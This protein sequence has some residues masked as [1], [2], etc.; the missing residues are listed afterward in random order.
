MNLLGETALQLYD[1]PYKFIQFGHERIIPMR[2]HLS[3]TQITQIQKQFETSNH[4]PEITFTSVLSR[5]QPNLL[6]QSATE[7]LFQP[8]DLIIQEGDEGD[9]L[10]IIRAGAVAVL[11]GSL[12]SP[13]VLG[14]RGPGEVVGEVALLDNRPRS[15]SLAAVRITRLL[16]IKREIIQQLLTQDPSASAS[17]MR[18]LTARLRESDNAIASIAAKGDNISSEVLHLRAEKERLLELQY[19][20]ED[21]SNLVVNDLRIPLGNITNAIGLL[22]MVLPPEIWNENLEAFE[23]AQRSAE[24]LTRMAESLLEMSRLESG[25]ITLHRTE[26]DLARLVDSAC[27]Q[28]TPLAQGPAIIMK[29]FA[30]SLPA[31]RADRELLLRVLLNL[32][33]NA[34]KHTPAGGIITLYIEPHRTRVQVA[35]ND[36]GTGVPPDQRERIFERFAHTEQALPS[37]SGFGLGLAFCRLAVEAHGGKIWAEDGENGV[38]TKFIFSLPIMGK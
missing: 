4:I 30:A 32:L 24:R 21:M 29:R 23:I 6:K 14:F 38:G 16:R 13:T 36:P 12:K 34:L 18:T 31:I 26:I 28:V 5:L 10:Y 15:A 22:R 1:L 33:D 2:P 7:L 35:V 20:R 11:K 3:P 9:A 19:M 37:R 8:G 25:E 27:E 17:L